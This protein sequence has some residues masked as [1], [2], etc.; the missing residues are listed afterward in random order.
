MRQLGGAHFIRMYAGVQTTLRIGSVK[1]IVATQRGVRAQYAHR[2]V[3]FVF[4]IRYWRA[5]GRA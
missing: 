2:V 1:M 5:R 3:R 4:G